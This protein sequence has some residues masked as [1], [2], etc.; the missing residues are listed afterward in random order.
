[1]KLTVVIEIPGVSVYDVKRQVVL[2]DELNSPTE[3][4]IALENV[5]PEH[6]L[7]MFMQTCVA[8]EGSVGLYTGTI[9]YQKFEDDDED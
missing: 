2:D 5:R 3:P 6:V 8:G 4:A 9:V 1:M 7:D